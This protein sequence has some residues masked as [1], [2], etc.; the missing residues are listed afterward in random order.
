MQRT[1]RYLTAAW[2]VFLPCMANAADEEAARLKV[3]DLKS[4]YWLCLAREA[5]GVLPKRLSGPDFAL[6]SRAACP[7]EAQRLRVALIDYLA[8]MSPEMPMADH[9]AAADRMFSEAVEDIGHW[10][11]DPK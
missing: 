9:V 5:V 6:F 4:K 10:Y 7:G 2:L 1:A 3:R 8:L 11:A